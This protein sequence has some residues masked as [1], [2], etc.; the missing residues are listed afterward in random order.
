MAMDATQKTPN[1]LLVEQITE[2][3]VSAGLVPEDHR[4]EL[5]LKLKGGTATQDDWNLWIDLATSPEQTE[6]GSHE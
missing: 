6:R 3:L 2:E 1:E 5:E 4:G